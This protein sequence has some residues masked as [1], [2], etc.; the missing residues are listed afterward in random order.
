[1]T[2]HLL[3]LLAPLGAALG[4]EYIHQPQERAEKNHQPI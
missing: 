1:M 3:V 2:L 4:V